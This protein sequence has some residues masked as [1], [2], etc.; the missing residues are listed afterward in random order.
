MLFFHALVVYLAIRADSAHAILR[1]RSHGTHDYFALHIHP[2][3]S[4]DE[5][6]LR[7]GL[8]HEGS[9]GELANHHAFSVPN[10]PKDGNSAGIAQLLYI[11]REAHNGSDAPFWVSKLAPAD[12]SLQRRIIPPQELRAPDKTLLEQPDDAAV[13][14]QG[15]VVS[16]L[17]I[18]DPSFEQW[19]LFNTVQPGNDLNVTG[20]WLDGG[21]GEGVTVAVIDDGI[22]VDSRDL[23]PNYY[24]RGSYD[25][26]DHSPKPQPRLLD[27]HHG[28]LCAAEIAAAKNRICGVGVAYNSQ[29]AGIR[30]LS[31]PVDDIDQ[32]AAINYD[33][34]NNH[35]YSCS[36]GPKDDGET[37][38]SP[39]LLVQRA[40]VNGV[41]NGR[42]G[43]GVTVGAIDRMDTHPRYAE[44]CSAQLVVAYSSGHGHGL[45]ST[46]N[47]DQCFSLHS[48]TSAAAPLAAGVLALALSVRPELTWRDVQYLLVESAVPV[49][50]SDGSWQDTAGGRLFSHDWGYGKLDAY[51]LVSKAR[52][53]ELVKPQAWLHSAW[54]EVDQEI[55]EGHQGQSSYYEVSSEMLRTANLA[56]LEHVTVTINVNHTSRGDLSVELVSP[57]GIVSYLSTSRMPDQHRTGYQDWEFMSVA[58]WYLPFPAPRLPQITDHIRGESGV[59]TWRVIVKDTNVNGHTGTFINWRLNLWG[60]AMDGSNQSLHPFPGEPMEYRTE[61]AVINPPTPAVIHPPGDWG[62]FTSYPASR[63]WRPPAI[64]VLGTLLTLLALCST[65]VCLACNCLLAQ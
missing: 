56:Q 28:T 8:Q 44:S 4:P 32:A 22:D 2:Q 37:M 11:A 20:I 12:D 14:A 51:A 43:K 39:G 21:S 13:Q 47:G 42:G 46:D 55:A 41:Q 38:K 27:D 63:P 52:S 26:N 49:H 33:Y 18:K 59:G 3:A 1:R 5:V 45:Y 53:W 31:G 23:Q 9:I 61:V 48:G 58:H 29:V 15:Q 60:E 25:F 19:H 17:G 30:M 40:I 7:L 6:A 50:T 36:W 65:L 35:I 64:L 54:Q 24:A 16:L 62:S 34:Q 10:V 57:S